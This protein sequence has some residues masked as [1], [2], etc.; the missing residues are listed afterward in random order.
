[1]AEGQ[2]ATA[3]DSADIVARLKRRMIEHCL[4]LWS[5]EGWDRTTGGFIVIDETS[6]NTVAA[7]LIE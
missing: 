3:E 4:P 7:G 2:I 5:N 6:N 1:M